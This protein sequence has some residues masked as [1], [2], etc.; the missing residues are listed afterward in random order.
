MTRPRVVFGEHSAQVPAIRAHLDTRRYDPTFGVLAECDLTAFDLVVPL[1]VEEIATAR[2]A[3]AD[4][5]R[6]AAVPTAELVAL[7]DDKLAFNRRLLALG[8]GELVPALLP[9]P[10]GEYPF[11]RKARFGDFGQGVRLVRSPADDVPIP[12]SFCQRAVPGEGEDVLHV[13]RLDDRVRFAVA[14]RYAMAHPLAVR[15]AADRPLSTTP[16]DPGPALAEYEP[17]LRALGFEGLGCFNYKWV[18][19]RPMIIELNPRFGGSLVGE[20]TAALDAML[21]AQA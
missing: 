14:Y 16:V 8:F 5:R 9:D 15:G 21:S 1:R 18:E 20:V 17:I 12:D 19:G 13:L 6:R 10:P 4:G 11:V 3:N 7:C 2:R